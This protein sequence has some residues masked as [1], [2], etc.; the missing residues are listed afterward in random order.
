MMYTIFHIDMDSFFASIEECILKHPSNKPLIVGGRNKIG[1]VSSANYAARKLG[2]KSA[3]PILH[4]KK[5]CPNITIADLH[6]DLYGKIS[7]KIY[8]FLKSL[9]NKVEIGSIDEWYL[10]ISDSNFESWL[11]EDFASYIKYSIKRKFNLN[12]TIGCSWNKFLAKMGTNLSKPN[13]FIII[14]KQN[15]KEKIY[16]LDI[17]KMFS[18]GNT[19]AKILRESGIHKIGDIVNKRIDETLIKKKLGTSWI[20][21]KENALGISNIL[22]NNENKQ[23]SIGRSHTIIE[24]NDFIEYKK[25]LTNICKN[26]NKNL[27]YGKFSFKNI[28]IKIKMNNNEIKTLNIKNDIEQKWVNDNEII[29]LFDLNISNYD[30]KNI[31]N[32]SVN[33]WPIIELN[34]TMNQLNLFTNIDTNNIEEIIISNINN[35]F[36][37]EVLFKAN[38]LRK[39]YYKPS[40]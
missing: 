12:C 20:T 33:V 38:D 13:G 21:I 2:I 25:L 14:T 30:Y 5:I 4:A 18:I 23:K 15:F 26:L 39:K 34:N 10:D 28:T 19:K 16:D 7:H 3:M 11:E 32:I 22:I 24:Y 36:K 40:K 35:K 8:L 27:F 17:S 1:V 31:Q 37:S 9:T 29:S 6:H